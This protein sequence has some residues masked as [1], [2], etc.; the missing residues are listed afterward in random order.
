MNKITALS[1]LIVLPFIQLMAGNVSGTVTD[2]SGR[3]LA[4]A[5]V[6]VQGQ[7][8]GTSTNAEGRYSLSLSPGNY[9]LVC[10]YVGYTRQEKTITVT[11]Q[12]ELRIDFS[13]QVQELTLSEV[14]LGK[15]EDPPMKSSGNQLRS[16]STIRHNLTGTNVKYI[17][18]GNSNCGP[19]PRKYSG[20]KWI[21][22]MGIPANGK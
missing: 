16:G 18:R 4:F 10:Q 13:L 17:P 22:K 15:G 2:S 12:T 21:L 19:I 8:K 14:V 3:P 11:A 7:N 9:T 20:K 5:S 6:F 1:F